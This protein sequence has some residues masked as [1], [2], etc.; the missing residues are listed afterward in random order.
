[1][2][3]HLVIEKAFEGE[4]YSDKMEIEAFDAGS[5]INYEKC[6]VLTIRVKPSEIDVSFGFTNS[7]ESGC[8]TACYSF[9]SDDINFTKDLIGLINHMKKYRC[10]MQIIQEVKKHVYN[11]RH[12]QETLHYLGEDLLYSS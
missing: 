11:A 4:F 10:K 8:K 1:M 12:Y 7:P 9:N 3:K 2:Y 6:A 5:A